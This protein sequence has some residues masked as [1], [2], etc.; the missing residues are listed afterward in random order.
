MLGETEIDPLG[1]LCKI[2][3][4]E[5]IPNTAFLQRVTIKWSQWLGAVF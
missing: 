4:I 5:Q 1:S 3:S 2:K